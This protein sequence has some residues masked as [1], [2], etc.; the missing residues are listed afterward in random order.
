VLGVGETSPVTPPEKKLF[1]EVRKIELT[2]KIYKFGFWFIIIYLFGSLVGM[3][4]MNK[5][6]ENK[7]YESCK[8]SGIIVFQ[9]EVF[10]LKK[11]VIVN[12]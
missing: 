11:K 9:D 4:A 3:W 1:S 12:Q 8:R 5:Y 2:N 6:Y 10:E 7:L